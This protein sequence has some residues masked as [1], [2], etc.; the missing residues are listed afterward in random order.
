MRL[1]HALQR[2]LVVDTPSVFTFGTFDGVHQGH[3]YIFK[4]VCEQAHRLQAHTAILTFSN[5]PSELL[6]PHKPI[7]KLTSEEQKIELITTFGFDIMVD[8]PFDAALREL[9]AEQFLQRARS[10][11][12]FTL[13]VV[14]SDVT[15]GKD[16]QGNKEFLQSHHDGFSLLF[17]D[18]FCIDGLPVS[19]SRIREAIISGR[20]DEAARLL[21][22][23][24]A[25]LAKKLSVSHYDASQFALP[26]KGKYLA[27]VKFE[28]NGWVT[29]EVML[30]SILEIPK[31]NYDKKTLEV[32]FLREI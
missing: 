3:Q 29:T 30:T 8:L 13:L 5:H 19:S 21:G 28:Q 11:I 14:G 12:P 6:T 16:A 32:R 27:E 9:S 17:L 24:Y 4:Q 25:V 10:M 2:D 31:I 23:P 7:M 1:F 20:L 22:R 15:F 18:R 26:P